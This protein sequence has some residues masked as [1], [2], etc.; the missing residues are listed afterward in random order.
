MNKT[1][2]LPQ[3]AWH[4]VCDLELKIPENWQ[5]EMCHMS[6]Y[7]RRALTPHAISKSIKNPLG[8]ESIK[9]LARNKNQVAIIFDDV[10]RATR[11]AEIL[12]PI[13]EELAEAEITDKQIRFICALG[14]HS[15]MNRQDFVKKLG[16]NVVRRY[17]VY[18]HNPFGACTYIGTTSL[19]TKLFINAEV[20]KC[21]LKI[22]LGSIVPHSLAG[23]GGGAKIVLP[24]ICSYD[25]CVEFHKLGSI[26]KKEHPEIPIGMGI[27]GNNLLRADMEEAA[28]MVG[29]DIKV[30]LIMNSFGENAAIYAGKLKTSYPLAVK[31][32]QTH[33]NS[34][35]PKDQDIVIANAFTKVAE[36]ESGLEIAYPSI[37][38]EGGDVVLIGNAPEG[39]VIHYL[40]GPWGTTR[41][42]PFQ[43]QCLM[44]PSVNRLIIYS[45]YPDQTFLNCFAEPDRVLLV[46]DWG[47]VLGMLREC[48]K[49]PTK[50]AVYPNSDIQYCALSPGTN[51]MSFSEG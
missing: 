27:M 45:E 43:M 23:F 18:N 10:Q 25:T 9:K 14:C 41:H 22:A 16:E 21:D 12:P 37:R 29:L 7:N 5:V 39:H 2:K 3:L 31:D 30:D 17:P 28:E 19:G 38:K 50:V 20:M 48:H 34:P 42:N 49:G 13:L 32:A 51:F 1:L 8:T 26:Y 4:G 33:Y 24:G 40:A 6:G 46:S 44:P 35:Q 15:P 47:E 11:T 36:S